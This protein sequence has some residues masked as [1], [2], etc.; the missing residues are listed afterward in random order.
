MYQRSPKMQ[1]KPDI[2]KEM[3][4]REKLARWGPEYEGLEPLRFETWKTWS[5][6]AQHHSNFKKDLADNSG[7]DHCS[8]ELGNFYRELW[9]IVY[10]PELHW[11]REQQ[12]SQEETLRFHKSARYSPEYRPAGIGRAATLRKKVQEFNARSRFSV[13]RAERL[14]HMGVEAAVTTPGGLQHYLRGSRQG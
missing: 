4:L 8:D 1:T 13:G 10:H 6:G 3:T 11:E 12:R 5:I 7:Y 2:E 9:G 14:R